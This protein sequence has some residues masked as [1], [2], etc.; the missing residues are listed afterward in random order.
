MYVTYTQ[1]QLHYK[2]R[3]GKTVKTCWIADIKRKHGE[4]NHKAYNRIGNKPK[5]PCP[6]DVFDNLERILKELHM[7]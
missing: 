6:D 7:I 5:Y 1:A 2:K 3:Y 4:T